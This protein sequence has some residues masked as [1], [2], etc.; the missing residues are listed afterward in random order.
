MG[1]KTDEIAK[2]L[3]I[4]KGNKNADLT[5]ITSGQMDYRYLFS[6]LEELPLEK[7]NQLDICKTIYERLVMKFLP[8]YFEE[9]NMRIKYEETII[10]KTKEII[11][12][13]QKII[14]LGA[15]VPKEIQEEIARDS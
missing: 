13:E 5:G 11:A 1:R 14:K 2:K 15:H 4:D 6:M 9:R 7:M 8:E 12:L 3:G 10:R